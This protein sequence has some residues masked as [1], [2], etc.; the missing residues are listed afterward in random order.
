MVENKNDLEDRYLEICLDIVVLLTEK[1]TKST[2]SI[3][4]IRERLRIHRDHIEN[5]SPYRDL[6]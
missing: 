4:E 3:N 5:K 6:T 2:I 1:D